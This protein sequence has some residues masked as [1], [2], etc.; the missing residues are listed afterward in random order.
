MNK[1]EV[2][3]DFLF[4]QG[5]KWINDSDPQRVDRTAYIFITL[6]EGVDMKR[7]NKLHD[8]YA[9]KDTDY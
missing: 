8:I 7:A 9:G 2:I 5:K 3:A 1:E 6:L 4:K